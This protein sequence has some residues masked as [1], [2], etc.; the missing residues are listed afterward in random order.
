M[1][2]VTSNYITRNDIPIKELHKMDHI[3]VNDIQKPL[4]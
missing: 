1:S 2:N 4:K 3:N